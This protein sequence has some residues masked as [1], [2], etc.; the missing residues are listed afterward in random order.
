M[1]Y[2]YNRQIIKI[3]FPILFCF[4][5]RVYRKTKFCYDCLGAYAYDSFSTN[6]W[7]CCV[8]LM[9]SDEYF[10][11]SCLGDIYSGTQRFWQSWLGAYYP[12]CMCIFFLPKH[13]LNLNKSVSKWANFNRFRV[14]AGAPAGTAGKNQV[15][16][17]PPAG[18]PNTHA[19]TTNKYSQLASLSLPSPWTRSLKTFYLISTLFKNPRVLH[20]LAASPS[21][22]FFL[23]SILLTDV[24]LTI[25]LLTLL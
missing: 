2:N 10:L 4:C 20:L 21:P 5:E 18:A 9:F 1:V 25:I 15:P 23:I 17:L 3:T 8:V 24:H 22:Y 7:L 14:G 19:H 6:C 12:M 16:S 13:S 11:F